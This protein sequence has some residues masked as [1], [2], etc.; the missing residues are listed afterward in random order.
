M[1]HKDI[2]HYGLLS[3]Q[4]KSD[5]HLSVFVSFPDLAFTSEDAFGFEKVGSLQT[6]PI[7]VS[8]YSVWLKK[9]G[10]TGDHI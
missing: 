7:F 6:I 8:I 1:V 2:Q 5:I 4:R 3:V 10:V 9:D